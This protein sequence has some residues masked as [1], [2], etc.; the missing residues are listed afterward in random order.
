MTATDFKQVGTRGMKLF[1]KSWNSQKT[2]VGNIP[3][4]KT[5]YL[6]TGNSVIIIYKRG[7][8]KRL[9]RP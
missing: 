8:L 7:I 1:G 6:V 5:H 9:S 3:Q 2:P 4:V